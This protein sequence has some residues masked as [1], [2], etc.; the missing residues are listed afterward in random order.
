MS[1]AVHVEATRGVAE[2]WP[3]APGSVP[4]EPIA[5]MNSA[6]L[7]NTLLAIE[8][9]RGALYMIEMSRYL[10]EKWDL[11]SDQLDAQSDETLRLVAKLLRL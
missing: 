1:R 8:Q 2:K 4:F 6:S 9:K 5:G 11:G 3:L 10:V 7:A